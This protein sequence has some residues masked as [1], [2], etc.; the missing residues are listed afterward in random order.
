M[1]ATFDSAVPAMVAVVRGRLIGRLRLGGR[2][3]ILWSRL[4]G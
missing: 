2:R 1:M 4:H 3:S